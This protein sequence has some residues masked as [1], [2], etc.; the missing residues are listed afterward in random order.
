MPMQYAKGL[1]LLVTLSALF[2]LIA[3]ANVANLLLARGSSNRSLTAV[4]LALGAP[5]RRLIQQ[6]LM[7]VFCW[8]SPAARQGST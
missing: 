5:R 6:L 2:L 4:R 1:R 7:K 8:R 3:C